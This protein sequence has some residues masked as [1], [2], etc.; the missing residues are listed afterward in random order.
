MMPGWPVLVHYTG[1][2]AEPK[3]YSRILT[4]PTVA[5]FNGDGIPDVLVGSN[6]RLGKGE[7]A[8]ARGSDF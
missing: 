7:N 1:T 2:H 3:E 4:T 5:D 8:G 6:E